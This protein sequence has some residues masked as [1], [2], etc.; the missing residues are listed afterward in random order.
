MESCTNMRM[1]MENKSQA[2]KA[3]ELIAEITAK[4]TPESPNE[5]KSF[6]ACVKVKKNAVIVDGNWSLFEGTFL[7]M[8]PE[9]FKTCAALTSQ[10]F[11]AH[12]YYETTCAWNAT[13]DADRNANSLNMKTVVSVNGDGTCPECG[14]TIVCFDE[15]DPNETYYCPECGDEI[16]HEEMF[17]GKP[18]VITKETIIIG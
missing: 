3:A 9:I 17:G 12:A 7:E 8:I 2:V 18:P 13:I 11:E 15:Y 1:T 16:G 5:L 6:L 14:E 4:R 10:K